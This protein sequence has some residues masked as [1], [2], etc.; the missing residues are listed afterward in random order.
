MKGVVKHVITHLRFSCRQR[1]SHL[2]IVEVVECDNTF[3][4]QPT[5][6]NMAPDFQAPGA[7]PPQP[8]YYD[9]LQI[10]PS[11]LDS[12]QQDRSQALKRAYHRALLIHH[13]DKQNRRRQRSE[14]ADAGAAG[15][16]VDQI[17]LAYATLASPARRAA[18]DKALLLA[19]RGSSSSLPSS[20]SPGESRRFFHTGI[21]DADLDDLEFDPVAEEW[22]RA[23]RCGNP[24]GY[25][26]GEADLEETADF[27]EVMVGCADCSLWLRVR[28]A[29]VVEDDDGRE[30]TDER[31]PGTRMGREGKERRQER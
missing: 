31:A 23:C 12:A 17:S 21:Q 19:A 4:Q 20:S 13:P 18:Y 25:R 15:V 27:G 29:V 30:S 6:R 16:T 3:I 24:R 28:F 14:A 9:I 22:F 8:T 1:I 5:P 10:S 7:T 26:F 2:N 11:S